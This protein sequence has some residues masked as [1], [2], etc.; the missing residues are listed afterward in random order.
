MAIEGNMK[1]VRRIFGSHEAPWA[2]HQEA[3]HQAEFDQY[4][5]SPYFRDL[6]F[7]FSEGQGNLNLGIESRA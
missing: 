1:A 7:I 6:S 3:W 5:Q 2:L 4:L